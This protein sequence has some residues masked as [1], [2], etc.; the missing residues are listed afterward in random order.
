MNL[1]KYVMAAGLVL[2]TLGS[3]QT[4]A[5]IQEIRNT[6]TTKTGQTTL[7]I[8]PGSIKRIN[9]EACQVTL[10]VDNLI[11]FVSLT[12]TATRDT[13]EV[14]TLRY[15]GEKMGLNIDKTLALFGNSDNLPVTVASELFE[16]LYMMPEN[17]GSPKPSLCERQLGETVKLTVAGSDGQFNAPGG[18]FDIPGKP[19]MQ[20][21]LGLR[22][23]P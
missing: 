7:R 2:A 11:Q 22:A 20:T 6:I 15:C 13:F 23:D 19:S 9:G 17:L 5:A 18:G 4:Q 3:L 16:E 14:G 21:C 8:V 12:D 1:S 10:S